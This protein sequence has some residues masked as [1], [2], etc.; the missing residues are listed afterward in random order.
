MGL[1]SRDCPISNNG[2]TCLTSSL[3]VKTLRT[4]EK[5]SVTYERKAAVTLK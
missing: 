2:R 3:K 5:I 4:S 1:L